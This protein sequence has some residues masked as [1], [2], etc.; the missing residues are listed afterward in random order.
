[1]SFYE[2][3]DDSKR[4]IKMTYQALSR[5][6]SSEDALL[7]WRANQPLRSVL[8]SQTGSE[9]V[10]LEEA[11]EQLSIAS[12]D[13][14]HN[15]KINRL[16]EAARQKFEFDASVSLKNETY[17]DIFDR[18]Y[19]RMRLGKR[20]ITAVSSVTYFDNTNATQTLSTD[21]YAFDESLAEIRLKVNQQFPSTES[22][23]DAVTIRYTTGFTNAPQTAKHA[24]LLLVAFWFENADMIV[25]PNLI[26]TQAYDSLVAVHQRSTYP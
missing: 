23:W 21:V 11:K 1:L 22:R 13:T 6:Y 16:I 20:Q 8:V 2:T 4:L 14:S 12:S 5:M 24:I 3:G 25:S 15:S 9:V 10:T 17:D 26:S 19:D 7:R 18:F